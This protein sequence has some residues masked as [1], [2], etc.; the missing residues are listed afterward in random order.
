MFIVRKEIH[1]APAKHTNSYKFSQGY[2]VQLNSLLLLRLV[3]FSLTLYSLLHQVQ[4]LLELKLDPFHIPHHQ[5]YLQLIL[6]IDFQC[7]KQIKD[8]QMFDTLF[9]DPFCQSFQLSTQ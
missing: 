3:L 9:I 6:L 5:Y 7:L 4:H 1:E 8:N 2:Q